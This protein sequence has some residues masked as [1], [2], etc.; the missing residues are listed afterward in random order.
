MKEIILNKCYV[1]KS[2]R[3]STK[4]KQL[5]NENEI[6]WLN[7]TYPDSLSIKEQLFR[8]K[9]NI[10]EIPKCPICGNNT[11][12]INIKYTEFCSVDCKNK[13]KDV[14]CRIKNTKLIKYGNANY[15]NIIK[16]IKTCNEKYN[17]DNYIQSNE[18][19]EKYKKICIDKFGVDNV[20][21]SKEIHSIITKH[22]DY[23]LANK[24]RIQTNLTKYGVKYVVCLES[25]R[26]KR[27]S[28]E[29][30]LKEYNTKKI[31]GTFNT[32]SW[33]DK[34]YVMLKE[35]YPD[36]LR[37]YRDNIR[38]PWCCDFYIPS[39]DLFI[40]C[41]YGWTHGGHPYD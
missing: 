3:L 29:S 7:D 33:E 14:A 22:T 27:K 41:N 30:K 25:L 17:V 2:N 28:Y 21:K 23:N 1:G 12:F 6:E 16:R 38:Y 40:E 35:V 8:L 15:N 5:L 10:V 31:N 18:F 26:E 34:S 32:S 19:K 11:N 39:K 4:Y 13:S 24:H 20:G 9:H 37:Q 36:V